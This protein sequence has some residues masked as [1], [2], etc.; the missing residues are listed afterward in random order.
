MDIR[1]GRYATQRSFVCCPFMETSDH[2]PVILIVEDE[3][4]LRE[5][6]CLALQIAE[7]EVVE[8]ATADA[9]LDILGSGT[10]V[11]VLFTDIQMP[12]RINGLALARIVST[13]WPLVRLIVT[14]G[15]VVVYPSDVPCGTRFLRKPYTV[16]DLLATLEELIAGDRRMW[17]IAQILCD[18]THRQACVE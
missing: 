2:K 10:T 16:A 13:Q 3:A 14:S 4:I 7:Y 17:K 15:S 8:A 18:K 12:G 9:A 11:A 1:C 5:M 6:S